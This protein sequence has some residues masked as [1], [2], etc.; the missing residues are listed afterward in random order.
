MDELSASMVLL[1]LAVFPMTKS[2]SLEQLGMI[3]LLFPKTLF[4]Y[5]EQTFVNA[6]TC[7]YFVLVDGQHHDDD[8]CTTNEG[9]SSW[10]IAAIQFSDASVLLL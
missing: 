10:I 5:P 2:L 7:S 1:I 8:Q 4:C 6:L 3:R 9:L